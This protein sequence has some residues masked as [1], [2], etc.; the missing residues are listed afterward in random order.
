MARIIGVHEL[1]LKPDADRAV[2]E[3]VV[4]REIAELGL[5]MPG[6]VE[7]RF[8]IGVKEARKGQHAMLWV[9]E[10][11]AAHEALFGTESEPLPGP[12]AFLR[13]EAA[14]APFLAAPSPDRIRF[15]DYLEID[16]Y[17]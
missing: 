8:L 3:S 4:R 13:Y 11:Q 16:G 5:A 2:F 10:S 6:L 7:R 9:F 12:E 14:I 17:P 1:D 15:T